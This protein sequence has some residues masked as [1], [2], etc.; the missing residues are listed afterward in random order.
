MLAEARGQAAA[1]LEAAEAY[2]AQTVN[3]ALGQSSRFTSVLAEYRNAPDVTRDPDHPTQPPAGDTP[4][5]AGAGATP[6]P[7]A[8]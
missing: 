8:D 3:D 5:A 4:R 1:I 6:G 7:R 2:R